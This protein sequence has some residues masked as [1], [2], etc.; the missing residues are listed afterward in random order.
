MT[1]EPWSRCWEM[2]IIEFFNYVSYSRE[3]Y[4]RQAEYQKQMIRQRQ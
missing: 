4:R 2:G 3:Y 1:K